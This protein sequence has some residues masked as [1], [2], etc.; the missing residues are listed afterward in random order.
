MH[1]DYRWHYVLTNNGF[2]LIEPT[3]NGHDSGNRFRWRRFETGREQGQ[4]MRG[5]KRKSDELDMNRQ[6][7]IAL[8]D[9]V[10]RFKM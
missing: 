1:L 2:M 9:R 7:T 4:C 6:E 8:E 3:E 10:K 5:Q